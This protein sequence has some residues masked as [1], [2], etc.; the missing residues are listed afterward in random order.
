MSMIYPSQFITV[1]HVCKRRKT[2][3]LSA[4]SVASGLGGFVFAFLNF[5]L[6]EYFDWRGTLLISSAIILNCFVCGTVTLTFMKKGLFSV[7]R[8]EN[9]SGYL[10][11]V[12][13]PKLFT[14]VKFVLFLVCG[15]LNFI[16]FPTL[17]LFIVDHA[18]HIGFD[19]KTG[20]FMLSIMAVGNVSGRVIGGF[21][22]SVLNIPSLIIYAISSFLTGISM[23]TFVYV[24]SHPGVLICVVMNGL[25]F[26]VV[27]VTIPVAT[28]EITGLRQ[29]AAGIGYY[30]GVV[31]LGHVLCGP[32]GGRCL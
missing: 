4:M 10:V 23:M 20:S 16:T 7:T 18:L 2:I 1:G 29:Y 24:T 12:F 15:L 9:E 3:A 28:L 8:S 13:Q 25:F 27:I 31:G 6:L 5:Y 32:I 26:G 17:T 19:L 14:D 11:S 30:F 22:N 21:L